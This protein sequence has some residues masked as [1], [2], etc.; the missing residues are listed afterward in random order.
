[1]T[2]L[3]GCL[4][5]ILVFCALSVVLSQ[6]EARKLITALEN[7]RVMA[8]QLE[9]EWGKLQLE[10]STLAAHR[11]IAR[12]AKEG[13]KMEMPDEARQHT[14]MPTYFVGLTNSKRALIP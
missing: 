5:L 4:A 7:E 3:N 8:R 13:L 2:K 1:M 9:V 14:V 6:H 11:N 10:Q 12:I